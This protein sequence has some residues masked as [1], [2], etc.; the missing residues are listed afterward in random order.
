M[1]RVKAA[2]KFK[3]SNDE[4]IAAKQRLEE[5]NEELAKL[6]VTDSLTQIYNHTFLVNTLKF[7]MG[8]AGRFSKSMA[9]LM[10]DVDFFKKINDTYGHL[11]GDEVLKEVVHI[12]K[13]PIRAVDILGRYGGEE[14]GLILPE[15]DANGAMILAEKIRTNV[16]KH[17]FRV[18]NGEIK[19]EL[20]LTISIGVALFP[21]ENVKDVSSII[22]N[23]DEA[24]YMAKRD[25]RNKIYRFS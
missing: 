22:R 9:F 13:G 11:I 18:T 4:L 14:F 24:L 21:G 1:A 25:G 17:A 10:I 6:A 8:R 23:A 15:T 7:E 16:E 19:V 12:I 3:N 2:L 5:M 20:Q